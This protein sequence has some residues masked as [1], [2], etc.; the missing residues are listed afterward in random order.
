ME[1]FLYLLALIFAILNLVL[2]FKIWGMTNDVDRIYRLLKK[3]ET[4]VI[5]PKEEEYGKPIADTTIRVDDIVILNINGR[6]FRVN[7]IENG[8]YFCRDILGL[9][10]VH[11]FREGEI[12]KDLNP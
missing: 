12:R 11:K 9:E 10:G 5:T 8:I 2:F 3:R 4:P 1:F 6:R 7:D